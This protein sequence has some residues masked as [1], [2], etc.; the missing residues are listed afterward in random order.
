M[1]LNDLSIPIKECQKKKNTKQAHSKNKNQQG[2]GDGGMLRRTE[3]INTLEKIV[4]QGIILP[5]GLTY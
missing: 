3:G 4:G 5:A 2:G 1:S